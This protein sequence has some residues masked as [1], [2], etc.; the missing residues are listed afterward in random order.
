MKAFATESIR[1]LTVIGHGDAGKTQLVSSLLYLSG[2][3]PRWG[4]VDE[5]TTVTDHDEDSIERKITLNTALAH[6]EYK[7][8]KINLIDTPGYAAFISHARPA[9]RVADCALVVVDAVNG[10]QVQTEKTWAYAN[11][12]LLP[13]FMAVTKLDKERADFGAALDSARGT[14][15]RA[16]IPF[17]LP[18]GRE[19]DFKGVVDVVHMKAYEFDEHG[20][21]R[22]VEIPADGRA[23]VDTTREKLVELVAESD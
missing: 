3:T 7:E 8:T 23:L 11:E 20:K 22:E 15:S 12:F 21:A 5:G 18:I 9:L 17:T 13:R 2:A 1:N 19:K 16:I 10:V 14:F 6:L 4:K